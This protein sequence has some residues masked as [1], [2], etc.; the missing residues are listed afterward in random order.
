MI[1]KTKSGSIYEIDQDNNR[2]RRLSNSQGK[3]P[4]GRLGVDG[5]WIDYDYLWPEPEV[6]MRLI[7]GWEGEENSVFTSAVIEIID[8]KLN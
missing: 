7:L 8:D 3:P 6:G 1:V 5:Q 2:I 4:V